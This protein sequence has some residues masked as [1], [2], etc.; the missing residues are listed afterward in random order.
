MKT[1]LPIIAVVAI[2]VSACTTGT[3]MTKNYDDGIYFTPGDVPPVT[4]SS[5]QAPTQ[6]K[7]ARISKSDASDQGII[8][9]QMDK[10]PDGTGTVTNNIYQP[11]KNNQNS[12]VQSY[13]MDN[14]QL[15]KSD[16]TTYYNDDD[17]KYVINN[18]YDDN[19]DVDFAYRIGRF[20]RPF[21]SPFFYDDWY[22]GFNSP[23]Y[24]GYY[25]MGYGWDSWG[26]GGWGYPYY[27]YYSPFSFGFGGYWGLG[28]GGYYP[29]AYGYNGYYGGYYGGGYGGYYG[30]GGRYFDNHQVARRRS[31]NMN[32]PGGGT[33]GNNM[34]ISGRSASLKAGSTTNQTN[35][36]NPNTWIEN[37]HVRSRSIDASSS[38]QD[39]KNATIVND[40]RSV[41]NADGTRSSNIIGGQSN[42]T[43]R[44]PQMVRPGTNTMG[45]ARRTYEPSTTGRTYNQERVVRPSQ[46]YTPSYNKPRIVNQSSYNNNS[47]IR[48]RT[49][50]NSGA[51]QVIKSANTG[52]SQMYNVPRSSSTVRQTYRSSS[53]YSPGSS[54]SSYRSSTYSSP[55]NSGRSYSEPARSSNSYSGGNSGGGYSGGSGGGGGNSGGGGGG[56]GHRR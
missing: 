41:T 11:D 14:Q 16:T 48:P 49:V 15:A 19:N 56:S 1:K 18:Y 31:T 37:G 27:G 54:S 12:D 2:L 32:I 29:Y 47:Y 34:N 20:Y 43:I 17:V 3:Y 40:R 21:Y 55:S 30:S 35:S 24:S 10:N 22:Y 9:R 33:G 4:A 36:S 46:N 6:E 26:W 50:D 5:S 23:W 7:S 45:N 52:N 44:T 25:G 53:S 51:R 8:M 38:N 13:N 28:Y 42:S 39:V